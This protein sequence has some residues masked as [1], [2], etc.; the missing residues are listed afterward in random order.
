MQHIKFMANSYTDTSRRKNDESGEASS[1]VSGEAVDDINQAQPH[2]QL[3]G[4]FFRDAE[5]LD[6]LNF[7]I[8]FN[9]HSKYKALT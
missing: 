7:K 6:D 3:S 5:I 8:L 4:R 9:H 1:I 2:G